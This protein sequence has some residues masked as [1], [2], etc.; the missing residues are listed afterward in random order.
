MKLANRK[1]YLIAAA[2]SALAKV[3]LAEAGLMSSNPA[4]LEILAVAIRKGFDTPEKAAFAHI[5]PELRTRVLIHEFFMRR[6]GARE[7]VINQDFRDVM[8]HIEAVLAF[9]DPEAD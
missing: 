6:V 9:A 7:P 3:K 5:H 2:I 4:V 1:L 8:R